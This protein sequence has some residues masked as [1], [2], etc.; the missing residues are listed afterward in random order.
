MHQTISERWNRISLRTK[1][2]GVTVLMLTLGLLVSGI[3]T[4]AMLRSYVE[5]Q[6]ASKLD[7]IA[8]GDLGKYF[9]TENAPSARAGLDED[10]RSAVELVEIEKRRATREGRE[11]E[12]SRDATPPHSLA[13][14]RAAR[15]ALLL[16][17]RHDVGV[18]M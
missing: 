4:A 1:I 13:E 5:D 15:C 8:A 2:T 3:G 18:E 9:D 17:E 16:L 6:M 11:R 14:Y 7:T 10:A 12:S